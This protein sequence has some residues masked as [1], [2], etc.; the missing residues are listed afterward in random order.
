MKVLIVNTYDISGGAARAAY[1]L[2]KA[3]QSIGVESNMLVQSK[4]SNDPT[5]IGPQNKI[6]KALSMIRPKWDELP[7]MCYKN[8][9]SALFSPAWVPMSTIVKKINASDADVVHLHW[10]ANGM[11]RIEDITKIKKPIVWSLHDMWAF[12]GGCHYD[13]DCGKYMNNCEACPELCSKKRKDLSHNIF[14]RKSKTFTKI[15]SLTLV[16]LSRWLT[17]C[18]KRSSLFAEKYIVNLPNPIDTHTFRPLEKKI[19]RDLLDLPQD[20]KLV[21]FGADGATKDPRKGFAELSAAMH[22]IKSTSLDLL[23][24]G[25]G[26][27]LNFPDFGFSAHYLGHMPGDLSLRILYSAADVMVVPSIQENLSNTIMENLACGT[28]VVAFD[29]GGNSDMI[30]HQKNGHL[31]TP[32]DPKSLAEGIDWVLDHP[33]PMEISHNARQKVMETFEATKVAGQYVELYKEVLR[34]RK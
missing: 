20:N 33:T 17:E 12:T 3:L 19:A 1:R 23:I 13:S 11:M 16:G 2:H 18:A 9:S 6:D 25:S 24:F 7:L 34:K 5:V 30:D 15:P 29:I 32:Y 4:T 10:I 31:A 27:S 8:K 28:P 21:L 22:L 14:S 26:H